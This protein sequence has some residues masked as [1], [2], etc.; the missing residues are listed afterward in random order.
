MREAIPEMHKQGFASDRPLQRF[1]RSRATTREKLKKE[2]AEPPQRD[3]NALRF[4]VPLILI[5]TSGRTFGNPGSR[6]RVIAVVRRDFPSDREPG[7]YVARSTR[8]IR[9]GIV[10]AE[11]SIVYEPARARREKYS[12]DHSSARATPTFL[13][14][15]DA[16]SESQ[17]HLRRNRRKKRR[18]FPLSSPAASCSVSLLGLRDSFYESQRFRAER[19]S[20][21]I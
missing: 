10:H 6:G 5:E 15:R 2:C 3:G 13:G 18:K 12:F 16:A 7:I 11:R 9:T 17:L 14:T 19:L 20:M 8:L 4:L 21:S 1:L